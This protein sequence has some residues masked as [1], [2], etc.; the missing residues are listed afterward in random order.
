M[1]CNQ[2]FDITCI[3]LS[4]VLLKNTSL[5]FE[6]TKVFSRPDGE[7]LTTADTELLE[8]YEES[9]PSQKNKSAPSEGAVLIFGSNP[10]FG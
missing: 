4:N 1:I 8:A 5:L 10:R 9:R 2:P 7:V 6:E 3:A